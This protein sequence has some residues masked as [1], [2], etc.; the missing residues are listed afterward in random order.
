MSTFFSDWPAENLLQLYAS[1]DVEVA[2]GRSRK[3]V[4][5]W[6]PGPYARGE[7]FRYLLGISPAWR[8]HFSRRWL[9]KTMDGWMPDLVY[10]FVYS[11]ETLNYAAW[12]AKSLGRPLIAH[13]ADDGIENFG[14]AGGASVRRILSEAQARI[15]I[16]EE[17][18]VE[19]ERRYE[20][21]FEIL[22]NGAAEEFFEGA[23]FGMNDELVVRYLGS[24][25]PNHHFNSIEDIASAVRQFNQS[26]G[27]A[28]FEICGGEWTREHGASI[29][30][31]DAVIYRGAVDRETGRR[32][33][34]TAD[35]LVVPVTF[36]RRDFSSVRFSLPTKVPEYLASGSPTLIYGPEGAAPV[37]F[38]RRHN[39]GSVLT[40]RSVPRLVEFLERL[41]MDPITLRT[42]AKEDR[43]YI[44]QH[45]S[46]AAARLKFTSI[47]TTSAGR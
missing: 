40:E 15:V 30:D 13:V 43:E 31:G 45:F 2:S 27:K 22:H 46:A 11:G 7:A 21:P 5:V 29:A 39:V 47:L 14:R 10:A 33:L 20:L 37:E 12:I 38:C 17:M 41:A 8:G 26:G 18:R 25:V 24:V 32:L 9:N 34:Q 36:D 3:A 28:R 23:E 6:V 4:R 16:S 1:P 42:K 35:L 19:Y 44:R